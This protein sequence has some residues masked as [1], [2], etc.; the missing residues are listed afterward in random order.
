M[1]KKISGKAALPIL[2]AAFLAAGVINA[3]PD[4]SDTGK[5]TTVDAWVPTAF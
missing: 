1:V 3:S 2:T 4:S 5:A